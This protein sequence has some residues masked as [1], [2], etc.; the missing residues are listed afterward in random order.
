MIPLHAFRGVSAS[1]SYVVRAF[2]TGA[3]SKQLHLEDKVAASILATPSDKGYEIYSAY[4]VQSFASLHFGDMGVA[5]LGLVDKM[6]GCAAVEA[7][8]IIKDSKIS[9][10]MKLKALGVLGE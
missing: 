7:S 9:V 2:T 5:N 4:E 10:K 8:D 1:T 6:T 3:V